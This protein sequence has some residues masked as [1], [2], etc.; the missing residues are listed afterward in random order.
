MS[1]KTSLE[2][3]PPPAEPAKAPSDAVVDAW[4]VETFHNLPGLTTDWFN[5][6]RIAADSLKTRLR[7]KES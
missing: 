6:F 2:V 5:R 7:A 4:F 1:A 3:L